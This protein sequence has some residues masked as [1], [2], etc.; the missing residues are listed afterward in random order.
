MDIESRS[1]R[2][3]AD[4]FYSRGER[5]ALDSRAAVKR[6][7]TNHAHRVGKLDFRYSVKNNFAF[8]GIIWSNAIC[9]LGGYFSKN[10]FS[11]VG[12]NQLSVGVCGSAGDVHEPQ[13]VAADFFV[14]PTSEGK[15]ASVALFYR[16]VFKIH[17]A[18]ARRGVI[19]DG[20]GQLHLRLSSVDGVILDFFEIAAVGPDKAREVFAESQ[21]GVRFVC[22][23]VFPIQLGVD[24]FESGGQTY[25]TYSK[26]IF[27]EC[28][29]VIYL[30][31]GIG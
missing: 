7:V 24:F 20:C 3:C 26:I 12:E 30:K 2:P 27:G 14:Q 8:F 5:H 11:R 23:S 31:N 10:I 1:K 15:I 9:C 17:V 16:Y 13:L 28:T 29:V 4:I 19:R 18:V 25:L 6:E 22:K 21:R